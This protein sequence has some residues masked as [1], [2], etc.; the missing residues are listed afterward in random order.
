[1]ESHFLFAKSTSV[2]SST[3]PRSSQPQP[4]TAPGLLGP[5]S[6][7]PQTRN[8]SEHSYTPTDFKQNFHKMS[9][10]SS[11]HNWY[12]NI[13]TTSHMTNNYE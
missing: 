1:M 6:P 12:L 2:G 9:L 4:S 3:I 11:N 8:T 13:G 10:N 7:Q 5:Q